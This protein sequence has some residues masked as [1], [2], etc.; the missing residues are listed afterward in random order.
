MEEHANKGHHVI[1]EGLMV[2][3]DKRFIEGFKEKGYGTAIIGLTTPFEECKANIIKRREARGDFSKFY[4]HNTRQRIPVFERGMNV[5][6]SRGIRVERLSVD[7]AYRKCLEWF[8]IQ[9]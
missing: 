1:Y 6:E 3:Y 7:E 8:G 2:G 9:G 4:P 5:L